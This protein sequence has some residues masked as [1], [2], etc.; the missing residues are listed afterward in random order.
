MIIKSGEP[1]PVKKIES[2]N[3]VIKIKKKEKIII[4]RL[5]FFSLLFEHLNIKI[6]PHLSKSLSEKN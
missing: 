3:F 1:A 6:Y 2:L 4:K 5:T